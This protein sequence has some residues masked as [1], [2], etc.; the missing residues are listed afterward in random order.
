ME[1]HIFLICHFQIKPA[2]ILYDSVKTKGLGFRRK[3]MIIILA[4]PTGLHVIII[5]K[6]VTKCYPLFRTRYGTCF[7]I[8]SSG[9]LFL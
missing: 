3:N 8:S 1:L 7:E 6:R 9:S 4:V 2:D 5:K